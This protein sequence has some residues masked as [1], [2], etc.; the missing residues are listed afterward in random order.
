M[1]KAPGRAVSP[2]V[3]AA[4]QGRCRAPTPE[5]TGHVC[6][7]AGW[8]MG[9]CASGT[10]SSA[11][12]RNTSCTPSELI[13]IEISKARFELVIDQPGEVCTDHRRGTAAQPEVEQGRLVAQPSVRS[14]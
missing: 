4:S 5:G 1:E 2:D 13:P 3:T 12:H 11:T 8:I 10:K 9:A 14:A 7:G 6:Y